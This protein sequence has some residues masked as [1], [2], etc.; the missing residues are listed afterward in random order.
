MFTI[1]IHNLFIKIKFVMTTQLSYLKIGFKKDIL[2]IVNYSE[3]F[4]PGENHFFTPGANALVESADN[5]A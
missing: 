2:S 4:A 1:Q 3:A 5:L